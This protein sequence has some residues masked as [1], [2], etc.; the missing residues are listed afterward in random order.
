MALI[1]LLSFDLDLED[2]LLSPVRIF[3]ANLDFL[4]P[5]HVH[6]VLDE[7]HLIAVLRCSPVRRFLFFLCEGEPA[8][9][10]AFD[11]RGE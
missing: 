7:Q 6:A 3:P 11:K 8:T 2:R 10:E 4:P 5:V 9:R 1:T